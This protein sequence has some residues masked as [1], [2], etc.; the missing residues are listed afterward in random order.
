MMPT[1]RDPFRTTEWRYS[2]EWGS[3]KTKESEEI[4]RMHS[5]KYLSSNPDPKGKAWGQNR[6]T[7]KKKKNLMLETT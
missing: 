5:M 1:S 4:K 3:L 6:R 7:S 2:K